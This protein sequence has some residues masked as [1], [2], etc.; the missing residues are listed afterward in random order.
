[1]FRFY[2]Y[3]I[4]YFAYL[5]SDIYS[6]IEC[7]WIFQVRCQK[8]QFQSTLLAREWGQEENNPFESA[9]PHLLPC[10]SAEWKQKLTLILSS[11]LKYLKAEKV[12]CY[13]YK[14][15]SLHCAGAGP[16]M[17]GWRIVVDIAHFFSK[18]I[19]L[20]QIRLH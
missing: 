5:G 3:K 14:S 19:R 9:T 7:S 4:K 17:Q 13:Y 16:K 6:Q 1:M 15:Y 11:I 12:P 2:W 18:K 10:Y 8:I 20:D